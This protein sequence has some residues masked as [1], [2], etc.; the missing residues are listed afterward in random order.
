MPKTKWSEEST[1]IPFEY[2]PWDVMAKIIEA[3][4]SLEPGDTLSVGIEKVPKDPEKNSATKRIKM[5]LQKS[6]IGDP[7]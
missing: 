6:S 7:D 3:F 2:A 4:D 1:L 5:R